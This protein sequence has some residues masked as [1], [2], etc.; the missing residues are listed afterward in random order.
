MQ[1][2]YG[3]AKCR[4]SK[5]YHQRHTQDVGR[6]LGSSEQESS[7]ARDDQNKIP[8]TDSSWGNQFGADNYIGGQA[9]PKKIASQLRELQKTHLEYIDSNQQD[10][11]NRLNETIQHRKNFVDG[12]EK[13]EQ[14]I[15]ALVGDDDE[16]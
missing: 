16:T 9:D 6:G 3:Q 2:E 14:Q 11:E 7:T 12:V 4:E 5:E 13:L 15:A 8:N 10:L 1:P